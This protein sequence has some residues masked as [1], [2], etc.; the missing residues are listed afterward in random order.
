[1]IF[2]RQR[3]IK[4]LNKLSWNG[5]V[6]IITGVRRAGKSFILNELLYNSLISQG[7]LQNNIIRFA[8]DSDED[9][10]RLEP[11]ANGEPVKIADKKLGIII[12]AKVFRRYIASQINDS[13][14]FYIFLDEVQLLDNFVGTLNSY[15][16][17][18]NLDIYVT[19]SNS[20]FLSSDI[21]TEFKGRSTE[22]HVQP[23]TFAEYVESSSKTVSESWADYI[24]TGGIPLVARMQNVEE[25]INYLENLIKETY[26]KDVIQR[27]SVRKE[28]ALFETLQVIAS[29]IGAPV[30]PR[31]LSNTFISHGY[32]EI[33]SATV[34]RFIDYYSDAFLVS[35]AQKYNI[36]GKKYIDS[37]FKIYFEDIGVRNALLNFRQI[38]ES[39]IMENA[40]YNE[41]RY[42]GYNVDIGE[43]NIAE[44]T[45]RKDKNNHDIYA[46]K[47]LEIDF[48]ATL[49]SE[50]YYI[51]SALAMPT[52]EKSLQ[53][54]RSLYYIDNSFKKIVVTK[55]GLHA[56]R[57]NRGVV[58]MDLF[59]FL[60]NEDSLKR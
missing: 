16:R 14:K 13:D 28:Q 46:Q 1:M 36:R 31:K 53:E 21:V 54:K 25:Q 15:L 42:R 60:L 23:L 37:L 17:H 35:K 58:T 39:H 52:E 30:N 18:A 29:S 45:G 56:T 9:I 22:V 38:E 5:L 47:S 2:N 34:S 50:K 8:F 51:Q 19:G 20:R 57:D 43:M 6:K 12:N 41:L 11:F 44:N 27:N 24:V 32:G 33:T 49:G 3:Y 40:I 7:V 26:L 55:N 4:K 48:I 10:D 59:D